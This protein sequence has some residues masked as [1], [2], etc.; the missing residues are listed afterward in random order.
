MSAGARPAP[1]AWPAHLKNARDLAPA[2]PPGRLA[3]RTLYR[4]A[5]PAGCSPDDVAALVTGL[6]VRTL[7]DLRSPAERAADPPG[8][9]L[10]PPPPPP[11]G[12]PPP[13]PPTTTTL[14]IPT[15]VATPIIERSSFKRA[16]L[17]NL[18]PAT[19]AWVWALT[20]FGA[21]ARARAAALA[22]LNAGGLALLYRIL[23]VAG[24]PGFGDALRAV[25]VGLERGGKCDGG[26]DGDNNDSSSSSTGGAV[27]FFC[28]MGKDRTGLMAALLLSVL[29]AGREAILADYA[30]TAADPAGLGIALGGLERE[31]E[32]GAGGDTGAGSLAGLDAATFGSAPPAALGDALDFLDARWGGVGAYLGG[33]C[34]F[35]GEWQGRLVAAGRGRAGAGG[36]AR[37]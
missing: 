15:L 29:G 17:Q 34:G 37:L 1:P 27:L 18:P 21:R 36:R 11:L 33:A 23:L 6:G 32:E 12:A 4:A 8:C 35:G 13:P 5:C 20:A 30:L 25:T 10:M 7:V 14:A 26:G 16:L 22:A 19:A 28:R 2:A 31:E 9:A 3:P 24:A